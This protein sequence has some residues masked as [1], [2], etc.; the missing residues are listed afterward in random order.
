VLLPLFL[1]PFI[2]VGIGFAVWTLQAWRL[3]HAVAAYEAPLMGMRA[4]GRVR[5]AGAATRERL[6]T[7]PLGKEGVGWVGAVGYIA[8]GS[9]GRTWFEP[10]CVRGDLSHLH[11]KRDYEDWS[12]TFVEPSDPVVLGGRSKLQNVLPIV[13]IG[14]PVAPDPAP[15]IP[16]LITRACGNAL[17]TDQGPLSYREAVLASGTR[18]EMLGCGDGERIARCDDGGAYLLTTSKVQEISDGSRTE[19]G[20]FMIFGGLW[21]LIIVGVVG[22]WASSRLVRSTPSF[23]ERQRSG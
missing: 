18:V 12:V 9:K 1:L 23:Q 8:K 16:D 5:V 3:A 22:L 20:F 15:P 7:S 11:L 13:D 10:V 21:N 2:G 17:P 14:D 4:R 19:A 6:V